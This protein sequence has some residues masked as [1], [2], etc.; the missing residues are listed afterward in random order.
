MVIAQEGFASPILTHLLVMERMQYTQYIYLR[1]PIIV[2]ILALVAG[3]G[4]AYK[5][6]KC[7]Q[8]SNQIMTN[9]ALIT[10]MIPWS[11]FLESG[12]HE[13]KSGIDRQ[14]LECF[15]LH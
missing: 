2:I 13:S 1:K 7:G 14:N 9:Y 4:M 15:F 10:H 6:G 11:F 3:E 8:T 5:Q 12:D